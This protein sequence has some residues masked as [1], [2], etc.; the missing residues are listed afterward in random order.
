MRHTFDGT[1]WVNSFVF[2]FEGSVSLNWSEYFLYIKKDNWKLPVGNFRDCWSDWKRHYKQPGQGDNPVCSTRDENLQPSRPFS[3][4]ATTGLQYLHTFNPGA[5]RCRY[6]PRNFMTPN[7]KLV[8][9]ELR[10]FKSLCLLW[11]PAST[12]DQTHHLIVKLTNSNV[13]WSSLCKYINFT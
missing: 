12:L 7:W 5:C 2:V 3:P 8:F 9:I 11:F 4:R 13:G 10:S 1:G 6:V